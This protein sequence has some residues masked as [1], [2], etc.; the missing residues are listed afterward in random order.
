MKRKATG[1]KNQ[2]RTMSVLLTLYLLIRC[3]LR[4]EVNLEAVSAA[5]PERCTGAD[6][7]SVVATARSAAVRSVVASLRN[8]KHNTLIILILVR[9]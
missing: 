7:M 6:L 4:P 1:K 2:E 9:Y 3:K 5:L 8:G